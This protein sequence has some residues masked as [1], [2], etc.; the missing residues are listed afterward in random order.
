MAKSFAEAVTDALEDY[1]E[2]V[3]ESLG[4]AVDTVAKK[5]N[6]VI[7]EHITFDQRTGKY[8]KAFRIKDVSRTSTERKKTWYV[9]SPHYRLSHLLEKG[10]ITRNGGRTRAFPHIKYGEEY[11]EANLENEFKKELQNDG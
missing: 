10:H 4:A 9:T 11:A 5:V 8:V 6:S 3:V 1:G 7:K 2:E